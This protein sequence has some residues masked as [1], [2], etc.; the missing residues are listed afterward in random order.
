MKIFCLCICL[1][2][3]GADLPAQKVEEPPTQ[4]IQLFDGQVISGTHVRAMEPWLKDWYF[5]VDGK[6]YAF[7]KV[8][9]YR[10]KHGYYISAGASDSSATRFAQRVAEGKINLYMRVEHRRTRYFWDTGNNDLRE[11][12][13]QN[14]K[15]ALASNPQCMRIM[16]NGKIA[17][18]VGL[19][20]CPVGLGFLV[21]FALVP[22]PLSAICLCSYGVCT[23]TMFVLNRHD[24]VERAVRCY[25]KRI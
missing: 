14:I 9:K 8:K 17:T 12:S 2:L 16:R 13:E 6:R 5:E 10:D 20:L 22:N 7:N 11:G 19:S 15:E 25:N 18:V 4:F 3:F 21:A 1:L 24:T 23:V